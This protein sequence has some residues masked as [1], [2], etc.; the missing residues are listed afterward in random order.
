M[1]NRIFNVT[2]NGF[3]LTTC[4]LVTFVA[5]ANNDVNTQMTLTS[6][7]Q[8]QA[9][10]T[11]INFNGSTQSSSATQSNNSIDAGQ[12]QTPDNSSLTQ[13]VG[14]TGQNESTTNIA[15][16]RNNSISGL[17]TSFKQNS[18]TNPE[19]SPGQTDS[20]QSTST[21]GGSNIKQVSVIKGSIQDSVNLQTEQ[22]LA[23]ASTIG[24]TTK[25]Q[26]ENIIDASV[27]QA[28]NTSTALNAT[29]QSVSSVITDTVEK[30]VM[31]TVDL[32]AEQSAEQSVSG[33]LSSTVDETVNNT[34]ESSVDT[35]INNSLENSLSKTGLL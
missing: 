3:L 8:Y 14:S 11:T 22:T 33:Q 17:F 10:T 6:N 12:T 19:A 15:T 30:N 5:L 25:L 16:V 1:K 7:N 23:T 21:E 9:D 28:V 20:V 4:S 31:Q 13:N 29:Q 24:Q 32:S 35:S 34:I 2:K 27:N 26:V 18:D